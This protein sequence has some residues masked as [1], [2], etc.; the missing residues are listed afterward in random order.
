MGEGAEKLEEN[1]LKMCQVV[2]AWH[3]YFRIPVADENFN[4]FKLEFL[5]KEKLRTNL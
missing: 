3:L 4:T 5:L 1:L 2:S